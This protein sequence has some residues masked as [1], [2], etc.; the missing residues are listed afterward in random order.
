MPDR[1][2]S[3]FYF[4]DILKMLNKREKTENTLVELKNTEK[5]FDFYSMIYD[6]IS[7]YNFFKEDKYQKSNTDLDLSDVITK[8]Y[9]IM[10]Y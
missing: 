6:V 7:Y 9:R 1:T 2:C 3:F 4:H 5:L 8:I 10:T